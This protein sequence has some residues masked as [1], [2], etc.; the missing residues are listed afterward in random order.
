MIRCSLPTLL[1]L[2]SKPCSWVQIRTKIGSHAGTSPIHL[3]TSELEKYSLYHH[4]YQGYGISTTLLVTLLIAF[5]ESYDGPYTFSSFY[6]SVPP[7]SFFFPLLDHSSVDWT[8]LLY[9]S[10]TN[11]PGSVTRENTTDL[12]CLVFLS[13]C[14]RRPGDLWTP[15]APLAGDLIPSTRSAPC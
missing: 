13:R 8:F 15:R 1:S 14:L 6:Y 4:Y 12:S 11:V 2:I 7:H 10:H 9:S 3:R 5:H